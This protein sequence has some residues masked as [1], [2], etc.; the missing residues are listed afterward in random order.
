MLHLDNNDIPM[1]AATQPVINLIKEID[2]CETADDLSKCL[3]DDTAWN[4]ISASHWPNEGL[5]SLRNKGKIKVI[6]SNFYVK[7]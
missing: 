1:T 5:I 4:I 7:I 6:F 2:N 3:V